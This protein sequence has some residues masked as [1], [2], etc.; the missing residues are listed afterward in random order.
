MADITCYTLKQDK[1]ERLG[2]MVGTIMEDVNHRVR[3]REQRS[4]GDIPS[5]EKEEEKMLQNEMTRKLWDVVAG[6]YRQARYCEKCL[7]EVSTQSSIATRAT[8]RNV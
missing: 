4:G 7:T 1:K 5:R 2:S 8:V 3:E 6:K